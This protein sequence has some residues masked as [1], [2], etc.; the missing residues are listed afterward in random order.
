MESRIQASFECHTWT[1]DFFTYSFHETN[2]VLIMMG[3]TTVSLI[4]LVNV[5][6]E[7]FPIW[8]G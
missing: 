2:I 4:L 5:S 8:K 3:V 7:C 1:F 6:I